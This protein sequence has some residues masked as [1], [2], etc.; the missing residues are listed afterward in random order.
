MGSPA[1]EKERIDQD[2]RR[3]R[4]TLTRGYFLGICPVT[5]A[6]WRKVMGKGPA[7][8]SAEGPGRDCVSGLD[9]SNFPVESVSWKAAESFCSKLS[10]LREEK[11]AGRV[12][13]LPTE[14]EWEH[15]CRAGTTTAFWS[16][17]GARAPKKVAWYKCGGKG[18]P[19]R[20]RPVGAAPP[21]PW[22]LFDLHGNVWEWCQDWF[23]PYPAAD[24]KDPVGTNRSRGRTLRGG[25][26]DTTPG[27][28]R[29]AARIYIYYP[30][31]HYESHGLRVCC[32]LE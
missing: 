29:A 17:A 9:T 16:G 1:D 12:Y 15:A 5:Q 8:F 21:N 14:A 25:A 4:V 30:D 6:Q 19:Q 11:K 10:A 28:C 13:R 31:S 20:P 26:W 32:R 23:A 3:H 24:R 7:W 27:D 2:E 22:G 18:T